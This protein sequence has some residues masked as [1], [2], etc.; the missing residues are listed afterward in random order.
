MKSLFS[1]IFQVGIVL[2]FLVAGFTIAPPKTFAQSN[3]QLTSSQILRWGS[4][5]QSVVSL[6][7][8]LEELG[9]YSGSIDGTFGFST[10]NAVKSYQRSQGLVADGVVGSNTFTR[11]MNETDPTEP[12]DDPVID[13]I[14]TPGAITYEEL[15]ALIK[16]L[17]KQ[18]DDLKNDGGSIGKCTIIDVETDEYEYELEEEIEVTWDIDD[19]SNDEENEDVYARLV[20]SGATTFY[21]LRGIDLGVERISSLDD[22][23]G[24]WEIP[25]DIDLGDYRIEIYTDDVNASEMS[26]KFEITKVNDDIDECRI[27]DFEIT[28][29]SYYDFGEDVDVEWN[30]EN[31]SS[32]E[33]E[34]Q[35]FFSFM[36]TND[37][38]D[39]RDSI[40]SQFQNARINALIN[41]LRGESSGLVYVGD[42]EAAVPM[43]ATVDNERYYL[44]ML[45]YEDDA[46]DTRASQ[47]VRLTDGGSNVLEPEVETEG[48]KSITTTS[49]WL[50]GEADLNDYS[51]LEAFFVYTDEYRGLDNIEED[52][53]SYGE[54]PTN[55]DLSKAYAQ[56]VTSAHTEYFEEKIYGL[57]AGDDYYY[58]ACISF[59]TKTNNG[60]TKIICGEVDEF[61][62]SDGSTEFVKPEVEED[63]VED[64]TYSSARLIG[65]VDEYGNADSTE[66]FFVYGT[67][68]DLVKNA[69]K[70]GSYGDINTS[71]VDKKKFGSIE[72]AL[73]GSF[74][75]DISNLQEDTIYYF[76]VCAEY[77]ND[78]GDA[79]LIG[80]ECDNTN[81]F[82]TLAQ[83]EKPTVTTNYVSYSDF[84]QVHVTGE[85]EM[86]GN[87]AENVFFVYTE[88]NYDDEIEEIEDNYNSYSQIDNVTYFENIVTSTHKTG[89]FNQDAFISFDLDK[90]YLV[91]AC[92]DYVDEGG[93]SK[94]VCGTDRDF[95]LEFRGPDINS[96]LAVQ[97]YSNV[98]T[99]SATFDYNDLDSRESD[100]EFF[101]LYT[102][103]EYDLYRADRINIQLP[104][105]MVRVDAER[106]NSTSGSFT[107]DTDGLQSFFDYY[108]IACIDYTHPA[109]DRDRECGNVE[110]FMVGHVDIAYEE[111]QVSF[112]NGR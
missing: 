80:I 64:I 66:L 71:G 7:E 1:R 41:A 12:Q 59:E 104:S 109:G 94:I 108:F 4:R 47:L 32:S 34:Y 24:T 95:E 102:T 21:A 9:F 73:S 61:E 112:Y 56:D 84:D 50:T 67:D 15:I 44:Y 90:E 51:E 27:T 60:R 63:D 3:Y 2:S 82:E 35:V 5:G 70:M 33:K 18:I 45:V 23:E 22:Q 81:E 14:S 25:Q 110:D 29:G 20:P 78:F 52:Y 69:T 39:P 53:D 6:Q 91:R 86:N 46:M 101:F 106:V 93:N 26:N 85:F 105:G 13:S 48:A 17:Q 76:S 107:A 98:S 58:R 28:S 19:C 89:S 88:D 30:L 92:V 79:R 10:L 42:K 103:E 74:Y 100:S 111:E 40:E 99:L 65:E 16:A 68:E 11:L 96:S 55:S 49:A 87:T 38:S 72:R 36:S 77:I 62:T 57:D 37:G 31:C 97:K 8:R 83:Y 43:V 54:I 75:V